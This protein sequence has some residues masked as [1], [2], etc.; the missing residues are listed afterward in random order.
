MG[1]GYA[2]K[3]RLQKRRA[4]NRGETVGRIVDIVDD[5]GSGTDL[6]DQTDESNAQSWLDDHNRRLAHP[7]LRPVVFEMRILE[8]AQGTDFCVR[9][10]QRKHSTPFSFVA[11]LA[12]PT[13]SDWGSPLMRERVLKQTERNC[14]EALLISSWAMKWMLALRGRKSSPE[15][16]RMLLIIAPYPH[17]FDKC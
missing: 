14:T 9:V 17:S 10:F 1:A 4:A 16:I 8:P 2:L 5:A 13:N 15:M 11:T 6:P 3:F 12:V 7:A